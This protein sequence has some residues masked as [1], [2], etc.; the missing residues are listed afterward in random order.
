M[1]KEKYLLNCLMKEC[2]K[3]HGILSKSMQ[4]GLKGNTNTAEELENCFINITT[5]YTFLSMNKS[6]PMPDEN[7]V[8][9]I[10]LKNNANIES[11]LEKSKE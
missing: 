4:D 10:V 1:D 6:V 9:E 3:M 5:Y 11:F 2:F 8:N 7:R